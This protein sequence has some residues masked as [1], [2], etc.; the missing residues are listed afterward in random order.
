M[1][2]HHHDES[3]GTTAVK[4]YRL[5]RNV[6]PERYKINLTPDLT[7]F[8]FSGFET[9]EVRVD[10]PVSSITLNARELEIQSASVVDANG[11]ALQGTVSIDHETEL[12]EIKFAGTLGKGKW[13]L[14]LSFTGI[15]NDKL[16]GFYRSFW[17]D[18]DGKK[19][20]IA[21]TQFESTDARRAFPCFD[22]PEFKAFWQVTLN[23]D[24]NLTAISNTR[25]VREERIDDGIRFIQAPGS[26]HV[27]KK[28]VEFAET[29]IPL[30]SYLVAFCVGEFVSSRPAFVNGV[31]IRIWTVPG[32]EHLTE[33]AL[34]CAAAA[35]DFYEKNNESKYPGDLINEVAIPDFASGAMENWGCI[36]Y[37]ET[38]L[39]CDLTTATHAEK[40]RVAEVVWHEHGH[41][42]FGDKVTMKWWNGLWLNESFATFMENWGVSLWKP[43]WHI[44]EEFA[45]SRAA[46]MRVDALNSTHPI[47]S[48][49]HH[50]D[51]AA[52]LFDVISYEKGCSTLY[53][54]QQ[55]IG[56]EIFRQGVAAYVA[57]HAF[58][59]TE[60]HDLWDS[61]E[62]ACRKNGLNIP[63][64][65]IMDRWVFTAGHPVVSVEAASGGFIELSQQPFKFLGSD[66]ATT[67]WPVPVTLKVKRTDGSE[68]VKKFLFNSKSERHYVGDNVQYV[69]VNAGGSGFYRVRY[70]KDLLNKL[71]SDPQANLSV[72]ERF[73]VV[74]DTWATVRARLTSTPDYLEMVK[75]FSGET[76]PNVWSILLGS[77]RTLH[78]LLKGDHRTALE[79][80]VRALIKP[81][82][83][84]LGWAPADGESVQTKQLRGSLLSVLGT[85][86]QET[87][88]Q[89]RAKELFG[90]W[91]KDKA[92]VDPNLVPALVSICAWTGDQSQYDEFFQMSKD[93]KTPQEVQRFL[94]ALAGFRDEKL[95]GKTIASTLSDDVRTQDA[96]YLFASLLGN[97]VCSEA[98]WD[99]MQANW[100]KMVEAYPDNAVPRM[101]GAVT[102]LDTAELEAEVKDFFA[103]NPVKQGTMAVAQ[104]LEQLR[105]N[106]QLREAEAPK[107]AAHILPAKAAVT[108]DEKAP[109]AASDKK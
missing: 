58:Q 17:T 35:T 5:P 39:L 16:K 10:E 52:E 69:V 24:E 103:K 29:A 99:F 63:V 86:G 65:D 32:K 93:A 23:V 27:Y 66:D 82:A 21:T 107:L 38:A 100:A 4:N 26:E 54:I 96:P 56:P 14:N 57:K 30:S 75:K 90:S 79:S 6:W 13:S 78:S 48:P 88:V 74:N 49:V 108:P 44:W 64:R 102:A 98:A 81:L 72:V 59:N 94:F 22:E 43:E 89:S 15:L 105:I 53:Q 50:P 40:K 71:V 109:V 41:M 46:A 3:T 45:L 9:I 34:E 91:K 68:E 36:T 25:I 19:H 106:V 12:A 11:T 18:K 101:V 42:D 1:K 37:R 84:K 73:N 47:E 87:A 95:L 70:G 92:A 76:D 77:L 83:D 8:T 60:T 51:D 7:A 97:E 33:F 62:E 104:A 80:E 31:E 2:C 20:A 61:L 85:I 67:V 28:T 55:F